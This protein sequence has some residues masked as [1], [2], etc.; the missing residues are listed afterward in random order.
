MG[1]LAYHIYFLF[2]LGDVLIRLMGEKLGL[3]ILKTVDWSLPEGWIRVFQ[4]SASWLGFVWTLFLLHRLGRQ[5]E[6]FWGSFIV[7]TLTAL[8]LTLFIAASLDTHFFGI[9]VFQG[10]F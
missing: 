7:H 3:D 6:G 5:R 4:H 9:K 10:L 8:L 1:Y 2:E